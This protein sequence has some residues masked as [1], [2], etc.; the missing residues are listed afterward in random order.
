MIV[1]GGYSTLS[2]DGCATFTS[3]VPQGIELLSFFVEALMVI[4][5]V[6]YWWGC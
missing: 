2:G 4:G 1:G 5:V 6:V 3:A